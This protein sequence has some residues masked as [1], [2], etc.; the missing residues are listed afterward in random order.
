M[1]VKIYEFGPFSLDTCVLLRA[2]RP[3]SL[4]PNVYETLLTLG[5]QDE[6]LNELLI[7]Y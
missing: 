3:V 7:S 1:G 2:G 5:G 4:E 6:V